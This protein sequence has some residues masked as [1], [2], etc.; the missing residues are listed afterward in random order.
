LEKHSQGSA[1]SGRKN[2]RVK[3]ENEF[4]GNSAN[5][6]E[7]SPSYPKSWK[8]YPLGWLSSEICIENTER[9]G[10]SYS[11]T[12]AQKRAISEKFWRFH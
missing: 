4:G 10:A 8:P 5:K 3:P 9:L 6:T 7:G 11:E 12:A 1:R 2:Q